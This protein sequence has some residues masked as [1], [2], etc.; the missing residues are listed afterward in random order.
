MEG[1]KGKELNM[2]CLVNVLGRVGIESLLIDVPFVCKSWYKATK[3]PLC[4]R[5][6][7]FLEISLDDCTSLFFLA[8]LVDDYQVKG[9]FSFTSI[10]KT[11]VKRSATSAMY[12]SLPGF[13]FCDEEVLY[14]I[15]DQCPNLI[16]LELPVDIDHDV[17]SKVPKLT[18][19]WK[20]LEFLR[21]GTTFKMKEILAQ[22]SIH[23]KNFVGF[24]ASHADIKKDEATSIVTSVPNI[25]YLE[26]RWK[27]ENGKN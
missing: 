5:Q 10:V 15:A 26:L 20:C 21:F 27:E 18:S 2:D 1:E 14:Y 19:N 8:R 9:K 7:D 17:V 23:Y 13:G 24:S 3:S 11:L 6:L 4:W 22:I 12:V 25:E 16:V